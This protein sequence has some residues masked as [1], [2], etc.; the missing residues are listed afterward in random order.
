M[1][2][3]NRWVLGNLNIKICELFLVWLNRI[4]WF[5]EVSHSRSWSWTITV[6]SHRCRIIFAMD[7]HPWIPIHLGALVEN[8]GLA[9]MLPWIFIHGYDKNGHVQAHQIHASML[10]WIFIHGYRGPGC[11]CQYDNRPASMLPWIFIHGY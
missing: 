4:C 1:C 11:K 6:L 5:S 2:C 7:F 9:S 3:S 8:K 10:P